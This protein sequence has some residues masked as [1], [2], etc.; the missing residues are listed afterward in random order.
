MLAQK[1]YD[2]RSG[3]WSYK[4]ISKAGKYLKDNR[5]ICDFSFVDDNGE[6]QKNYI[7]LPCGSCVECRLNY[8]KDW[9]LRLLC[10]A[11]TAN[12]ENCYFLTL[13]YN[14]DNIPLGKPC[15]N[16]ANKLIPTVRKA[17]ISKFM[18]KIRDSQRYLYNNT[19]V[20]F[21]GST[22]Y[23]EQTCR[24]HCHIILI[25]CILP[26]GSLKHL[27]N[28]VFGQPLYEGLYFEKYWP[29]GYV[30]VGAFSFDSACYVA[31]YVMKKHKGQDS[32]F[33]EERG[34]ESEQSVM[35]RVPGIASDFFDMNYQD[36]Y[37]K[38]DFPGQTL[39]QGAHLIDSIYFDSS[40]FLDGKGKR[41][42]PPDYFDNKLKVI[43]PDDYEIIKSNRL[44]KAESSELNYYYQTGQYFNS[45]YFT[46]SE[47]KYK[48]IQRKL[49][50]F[51]I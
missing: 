27:F 11:S 31:R 51:H 18:D 32:S 20:R 10:E 12:I 25:N 48:N 38:R 35:S 6:L 46:A 43:S 24:P 41:F 33:Y 45:Q 15:S 23:G 26:P 22:E 14:D 47:D 50:K 5:D 28:N 34:I 36:I 29:Y 19:G 30:N 3:K 16:L 42:T 2:N 7:H 37:I 1:I 49:K 44:V 8:S 4:M 9:S 39:S 40:L 17:D 13:T 21:Y